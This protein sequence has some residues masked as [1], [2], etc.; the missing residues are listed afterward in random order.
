MTT[1]EFIEKRAISKAILDVCLRQDQVLLYYAGIV[2]RIRGLSHEG[3]IVDLPF[4]FFM[5]Y[6]SDDGLRGTFEVT[7]I[8]DGGLFGKLVRLRKLW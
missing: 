4:D 1:S 8:N 5:N 7:Y 2:K 3:R 6:V